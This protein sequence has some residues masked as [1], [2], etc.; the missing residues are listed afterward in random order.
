MNENKIR[1]F[2]ESCVISLTEEGI[3]EPL[4][5]VVGLAGET[6]EVAELIKKSRRHPRSGETNA[7]NISDL[8]KEL[9]D[10]LFYLVALAN[11]HDISIDEIVE[12]NIQKRIDRGI[13]KCQ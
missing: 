7:V 12:A 2:F 5:T 6:G 1:E 8:T 9:G 3:D 11:Q 4:Y 10:V 13:L